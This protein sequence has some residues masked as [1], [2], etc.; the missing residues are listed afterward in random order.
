MDLL[1]HPLGRSRDP[2][3][4]PHCAPP[5]RYETAAAHITLYPLRLLEHA[6][7][8]IVS[9]IDMIS[10]PL[11]F[12][13]WMV[14]A[15]PQLLPSWM[16]RVP[17]EIPGGHG[18]KRLVGGG[19]VYSQP[20]PWEVGQEKVIVIFVKAKKEGKT[21]KIPVLATVKSTAFLF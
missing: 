7:I 1:P 19:T 17:M 20:L 15:S 6:S 14:C 8:R 21:R 11:H 18:F 16:L 12:T 13:S 3:H 2:N 4:F 9:V 10:N 5:A